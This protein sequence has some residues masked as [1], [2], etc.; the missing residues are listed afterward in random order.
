MKGLQTAG[1]CIAFIGAGFADS[2][3]VL[4]PIIIMGVG[5]ALGFAG[6]VIRPKRQYRKPRQLMI[7]TLRQKKS[8]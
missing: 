6:L 7:Y 4:V 3:N 8:A 1:I 5:M 2:S